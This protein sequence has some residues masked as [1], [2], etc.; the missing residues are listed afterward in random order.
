MNRFFLLAFAVIAGACSHSPSQS[1][2]PGRVPSQQA[3]VALTFPVGD[4]GS[5]NDD[6]IAQLE[7]LAGLAKKRADEFND[8]KNPWVADLRKA[9]V[10][11]K[12]Q[13]ALKE[14]YDK[15]EYKNSALAYATDLTSQICQIN[16]MTDASELVS[17]K[18]VQELMDTGRSMAMWAQL[19]YELDDMR[20]NYCYRSMKALVTAAQSIKLSVKDLVVTKAKTSDKGCQKMYQAEVDDGANEAGIYIAG[21]KMG[22]RSEQ[23]ANIVTAIRKFRT[24]IKQEQ[25]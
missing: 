21:C 5:Y 16:E 6:Q 2:K 8:P 14:F 19:K 25:M 1:E 9:P 12:V 17:E 24:T 20:L 10:H 3:T 13:K 23:M 7:A 11:P 15:K 22:W 4:A 18:A